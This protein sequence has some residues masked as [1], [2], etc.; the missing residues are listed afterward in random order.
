MAYHKL[1]AV[2]AANVCRRTQQLNSDH[3]N[4]NYL[5]DPPVTSK[6][7]AYLVVCSYV[8]VLPAPC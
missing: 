7:S 6:T 1:R 5:A 2:A 4:F 3:L 8:N